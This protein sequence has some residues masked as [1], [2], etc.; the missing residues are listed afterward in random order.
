MSMMNVNI[1]TSK[2]EGET[3]LMTYLRIGNK[4]HIIKLHLNVDIKRWM[5]IST[6]K[7]RIEN[8]LDRTGY[9]Q[10]LVEIEFGIKELKRNGNFTHDSVQRMI[11]DIVLKEKRE[12][13]LE[14]KKIGKE[15]RKMKEKSI[16]NYL[17]NFVRQMETGEIRNNKN[18]LYAKQS[19][20]IWKQ[21]KRIFLD[22]YNQHPFSW[23]DIDK[24]LVNRYILYLEQC[25]FLKKTR[26]KYIRL[27]KQLIIEGEKAGVNT[28]YVAK[29]LVKPLNI[30]ES[31]KTK[32]IY[33][34]KEELEAMYDLKLDGFEEIVRDMFL[35]GCYTAQRFSDFSSIH[36]SCI[37]ETSKGVKV[38]RMEQQKTG[39]PVVIPI[40]DD[41]LETLLKKYDYCMPSV[42]DQAF[43]RTIK[44]VGEKLSKSVPSLAKK[45]R[46]LLKKQEKEAEKRNQVLFERDTL[47]NVL[48][49]RWQLISTHTARRS[50][51][52][53]MYLSGKYTVPQMM[54]V[55]GHKD[56][57]T[58]QEYVKLSMDELAE[59]V[60]K[61]SCDGMF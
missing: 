6:S 38:I 54:S 51:I 20:K 33:L 7:K 59:V 14:Q 39:N 1:R 48:K 8:F 60:A 25:D 21:F 23:D 52:T 3:S 19:I 9:S 36:S 58:F 5:E 56:Q 55:S 34:T 44:E 53:N 49:P 15:I 42:T 41:K 4:N 50:G 13:F 26:D 22:F 29:S 28:N 18:E 47:G 43:N 2:K 45:E 11:E 17:T 35:I 31:D 46:T 30:K 37:G 40:L 57:R 16:K 10:R 61:S 32:E 24:P 27:F 12:K